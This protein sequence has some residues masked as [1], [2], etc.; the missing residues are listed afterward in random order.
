MAD[1]CPHV[2]GNAPLPSWQVNAWQ[3]SGSISEEGVHLVAVTL[4]SKAI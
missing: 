2:L 4:N 3:G 1:L